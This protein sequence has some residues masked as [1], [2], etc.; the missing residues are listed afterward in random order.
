MD[1][2][3]VGPFTGNPAVVCL[4]SSSWTGRKMQD[5]ARGNEFVRDGICL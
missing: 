3:T 5:M 1:A 2:F 4:L